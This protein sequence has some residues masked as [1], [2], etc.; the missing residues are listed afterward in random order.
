MDY[1]MHYILSFFHSER[2]ASS[3]QILHVFQGKRTPSMFYLA[4]K[5]G[6]HH[7]FAQFKNISE[8]SIEKVLQ[9]LLQN[10]LITQKDKGFILTEKGQLVCNEFYEEHYYPRISSFTSLNIRKTFWDRYQLFVQTFSE[11]SYKNNRYTPIIKH[12]HHQENV[13]LLFQTFHKDRE[14]LKVKWIKEQEFLFAQL[15]ESRANILAAQLTGHH[16]IGET[17]GQ[18]QEQLE[19]DDLEYSFYHQD[20]IEE[21]LTI[22]QKHPE[23][24]TILHAIMSQLQVET[25]YGLSMSTNETF[26]LL[27]QGYS[28]SDIADIRR[29]KENTIREHILELA[30]ILY[31]FPFEAFVPEGLYQEL[32]TAFEKNKVYS[33]KDAK[34][35]FE[36]LEFVYYRL[37]ELER[38]RK[39]G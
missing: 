29:L 10:G 6:W 14:S 1:R 13:R 12:P 16:K 11:M 36:E 22:I 30:F 33:Y 37:V 3:S 27:G 32:N 38:M 24:T 31:D 21:L 5:N 2:P 23:E 35:E 25:N 9:V 8:Q 18:V 28:I 7:A 4:E 34:N 19:M 17:K 15:D 20:S 26:Q 39:N